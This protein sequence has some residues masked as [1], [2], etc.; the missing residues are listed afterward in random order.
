VSRTAA[1]AFAFLVLSSRVAAAGPDTRVTATNTTI[2][3]VRSDNHNQ[4]EDDDNFQLLVNRLNLNGNAGDIRASLRGDAY[5]FVN[6]PNDTY[7]NMMRLERFQLAFD[8]GDWTLTAGDFYQQLGRGIALSIRKVDEAAL[9]VSLRGAMVEYRGRDHRLTL[10]AGTTNAANM[11]AIT[12]RQLADP[13]DTV[14]GWNYE[15]RALERANLAFFGSFV[16]LRVRDIDRLPSNIREMSEFADERDYSLNQ[17]FSVS[18]PDLAH[19]MGLYFEAGVHQRQRFGEPTTGAAFYGTADIYAG[20][21]TILLEGLYLDAVVVEGSPNTSFGGQSTGQPRRTQG[22]RFDWNQAPTLMPIDQ[23]VL[24]APS[25]I[26]GRTRLDHQFDSLNL[27]TYA[28]F[29][30]LLNE[31]DAANELLQSQAFL[32]FKST[33]GSG[34]SQLQTRVGYRDET[35]T[36]L[37]RPVQQRGVPG[38]LTNQWQQVR[39]IAELDIN[40]V[41]ALGDDGL[42][43]H[44]VAD[45]DIRTIGTGSSRDNQRQGDLYLGLEQSGLG[46]ITFD[47]GYDTRGDADPDLLRTPGVNLFLAGIL[48]WEISPGYQLTATAGTQRGG[49]K[50]YAGVCRIYPSFAGGRAEF[51]ARF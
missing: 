31:R 25:V 19:W 33:Y 50:C 37:R 8:R 12:R 43:L 3:E 47:L 39:T 28:S 5:Y 41:Q 30:M 51:V 38:E 40:W 16:N 34:A 4:T 27:S 10:L 7:Q 17:H 29:A 42:A 24:N 11:D 36:N 21:S 14:V 18:M 22:N 26:G 44:F 46:G 15:L 13:L 49:L 9:D 23:E 6:A 48:K 32:G 45:T 2:V 1:L 35:S 20:S